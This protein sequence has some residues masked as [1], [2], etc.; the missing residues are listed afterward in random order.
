G[1]CHCQVM[2]L[3][4][5]PKYIENKLSRHHGYDK[6]H[7]DVERSAQ[8]GAAPFRPRQRCGQP[9]E[10]RHIP[11]RIDRRPDRCEI[12]ANLDEQRR[13]ST[14]VRE[15]PMTVQSFFCRQTFCQSHFAIAADADSYGVT[16]RRASDGRSPA[17][18]KAMAWQADISAARR[19]WPEVFWPTRRATL[20]SPRVTCSSAGRRLYIF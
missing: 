15:S 8:R 11:D 10:N 13:H 7:S 19:P 4:T 6:D 16:S 17:A 5:K 1:H 20:S 3:Q 2:T 14:S 9:G 12:F 18:A